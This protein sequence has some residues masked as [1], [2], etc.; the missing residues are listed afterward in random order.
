M[1][2][3][4]G[5]WHYGEELQESAQERAER[6]IRAGLKRKGWTEK[7]LQERRKGDEF[8]VRLDQ[9]GRGTQVA[10]GGGPMIRAVGAQL[11]FSS[12][13]SRGVAPY[14]FTIAPI[15]NRQNVARKRQLAG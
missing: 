12:T 6:L 8:K 7:D 2:E 3:R 9:D 13:C 4:R 14:L 10:R 11:S 5:E 15:C 1:A